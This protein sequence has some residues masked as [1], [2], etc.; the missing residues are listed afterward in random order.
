[1]ILAEVR[2]RTKGNT[3]EHHIFSLHNWAKS[4][5]DLLEQCIVEELVP[6][7]DLLA[8]EQTLKQ[9]LETCILKW[10]LQRGNLVFALELEFAE[11]R[12]DCSTLLGL[13]KD[14]V[15]ERAGLRKLVVLV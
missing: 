10:V 12:V 13:A 2:V 11:E 15:E 6:N 4:A 7:L 1:M 8:L 9:V 14:F 3:Q 5:F